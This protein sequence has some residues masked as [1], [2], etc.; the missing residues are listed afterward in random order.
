MLTV[1]QVKD[2]GNHAMGDI[3]EKIL[4]TVICIYGVT[5][6]KYFYKL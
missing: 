2:D 5:A 6:L 3:C 1:S 4:I